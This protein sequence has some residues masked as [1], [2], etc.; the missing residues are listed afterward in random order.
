M[1]LANYNVVLLPIACSTALRSL[2]REDGVHDGSS[3]P[4]YTTDY[5]LTQ[6]RQ[7]AL[8]ITQATPT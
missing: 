2:G 7:P 3:S 4:G 6:V 5:Y 1:F 8:H